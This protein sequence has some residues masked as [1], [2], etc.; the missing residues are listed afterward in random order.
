MKEKYKIFK[1]H[2]YQKPHLTIWNKLIYLATS[3]ELNLSWHYNQHPQSKNQPLPYCSLNQ[4]W[5]VFLFSDIFDFWF[6]P[7]GEIKQFFI[8]MALKVLPGKNISLFFIVINK[9]G[10][11]NSTFQPCQE[12]NSTKM[13][14]FFLR[15]LQKRLLIS[16]WQMILK[17]LTTLCYLQLVLKNY[18]NR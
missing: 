5:P 9:L 2:P 4:T 15:E 10:F 14:H 17:S 1:N 3:Q 13:L 7:F 12:T 6:L 11:I 8:F 18:W 16:N